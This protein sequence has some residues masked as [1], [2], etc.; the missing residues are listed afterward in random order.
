MVTK[1][2]R[3]V[4]DGAVRPILSIDINGGTIDGTTIGGTTPDLGTFTTATATTFLTGSGSQ[5]NPAIAFSGNINT[6]VFS[7]GTN[8]IGFSTNG[9]LS[10]II[11]D[12]LTAA[13]SGNFVIVGANALQIPTG[14]DADRPSSAATGMIR[15]NTTSSAFEG[16]NGS[17][18][19]PFGGG[20]GSVTNVTLTQPAAGITITNSG[21]PQ[22]PT[23][24]FTFALANDL[25]ELEGLTGTADGS[26][27]GGIPKRVATDD[28]TIGKILVGDIQA[29]G[30]PDSTTFLRGDG[31]WIAGTAGAPSTAQYVLAQAD[32]GLANGRVLTGVA[33][34]ASGA[35]TTI[36]VD[37]GTAGESRIGVITNSSVQKVEAAFEGSLVGTGRKRLNFIEG[38]N[39]T[40][41][42][43]DNSGS[44]RYDITIEA[45]TGG[46]GAQAPVSAE[47]IV[48]T[49]NGTLT[50]EKLATSTSTITVASTSSAATWTAVPQS[51]V[52]LVNTRINSTPTAESP[53]HTLNF[54]A[55]SGMTIVGSGS[56]GNQTL[57]FTSTGGG[58][59]IT[60]LQLQSATAGV[61]VV[62]TPNPVTSGQ[63]AVWQLQL[64]NDLAQL[65]NLS[66]TGHPKR[67]G[68]DSWTIQQLLPMGEF[69]ATGTPTAT[70]FLGGGNGSTG[71]WVEE[72]WVLRTGDSMTGNLTMSSGSDIIVSSG[73]VVLGTHTTQVDGHFVAGSNTTY[74]SHNNAGYSIVE[75]TNRS[76]FGVSTSSRSLNFY[77][78]NDIGTSRYE[79]NRDG[80]FTN[81]NGNFK[82]VM[83]SVQSSNR[84]EYRSGNNTLFRVD[85]AGQIFSDL[86]ATT[87]ALDYAEY[88]E[89]VDGTAYEHG[90]T[91]VMVEDGMIDVADK[92][93][94]KAIIGVIRPVGSSSVLGG[95]YWKN[96][97]GK[98]VHDDFGHY[99]TQDVE[100][101]TWNEIAFVDEHEV[102]G[103]LANGWE[104]VGPEGNK[105]KMRKTVEYQ[106]DSIPTEV[107]VPENA[108]IYTAKERVLSPGFDPEME[109]VPRSEREE[110]NI[111]GL[112]GQI[113]VRKGQ[114]VDPRWVH[115]FEIS[116]VADMYLVR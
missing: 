21:V 62:G 53:A 39:V 36:S 10:V 46:G 7:P 23:P 6:G 111:V 51:S 105:R 85:T 114:R 16:Y 26:G 17:T 94:D 2:T 60:S 49:L 96:W 32:G 38:P 63:S 19:G 104:M 78:D 57:T 8:R 90:T 13:S 1:A 35:P 75:S 74:A 15:F 102:D 73:G 43:V 31:Q 116:D 27:F 83:H 77:P 106:T 108:S 45:A 50:N 86:A 110:W 47:Y 68:T 42:V 12:T 24:S 34:V 44:D 81:T 5:A 30:T 71:A 65:E 22:T 89:S 52:Q 92:H 97:Q 100:Y 20:G 25:A 56:T 3:D 107:V 101:V 41:G 48:T 67:L 28:W 59:G 95:S 79:F 91:V 61:N 64:V 98:Y 112:L 54:V 84:L 69:L 4:F 29:T 9:A 11:N 55:G 103:L 66:G 76:V 87:P 93:P 82:L 99:P 33:A 109:Y 70:S 72:R 58:S 115:M 88:F 37:N 113:P 18:W 80:I 40:I 14:A